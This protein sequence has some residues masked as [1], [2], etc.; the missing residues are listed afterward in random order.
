[1]NRAARRLRRSIAQR[2]IDGYPAELT[3]VPREQWPRIPAGHEPY[4]AWRSR[5]YVALLFHERTDAGQPC[6]RLSVLRAKLSGSMQPGRTWSDGITW[7]ELVSIKAAVGLGD[8]WGLELYPPPA[9]TVNVANMR[10]LW[11]IQQYPGI[12]WP[13]TELVR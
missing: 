5:E 11:C 2:I 8:W 3:R 10:H 12:G 9:H 7:D 6:V 13:A 1:M 4:E